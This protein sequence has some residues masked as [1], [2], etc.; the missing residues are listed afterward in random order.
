MNSKAIN[1][2]VTKRRK[3]SDSYDLG[4]RKNTLNLNIAEGRK[5]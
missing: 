2:N 1:A 5:Q 4:V 3:I